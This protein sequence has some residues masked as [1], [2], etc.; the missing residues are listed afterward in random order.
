MKK[1]KTGCANKMRG[2]KVFRLLH[3][4]L[5]LLLYEK[6]SYGYNLLERMKEIEVPDAQIDPGAVYKTL[7]QMQDEG[8]VKSGWKIKSS[9]PPTRIYKITPIGE[10]ILSDWVA[11]MKKRRV[12]VEKFL[13]HYDSLSGGKTR[14]KVH[15]RRHAI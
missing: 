11:I 9:G 4:L 1:P 6:S 2:H 5:L 15:T 7:R 14:S 12:F 10:S 8:L 3:P 13:S